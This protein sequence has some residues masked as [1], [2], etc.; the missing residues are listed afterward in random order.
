MMLLPQLIALQVGFS[1]KNIA[2]LCD[3]GGSTKESKV[4]FIGQKGIGFRSVFRVTNKPS[5]HS[6]GYHIAFDLSAP[7][8]KLNYILPTWV[9]PEYLA[10]TPVAQGS[11]EVA[12]ELRSGQWRTI[13][14]LPKKQSNNSE[15]GVR[16]GVDDDAVS[17]QFSE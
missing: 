15:G 12:E 17:F 13:I 16:G 4:G 11:S 2:A 8:G 5:V 10:A 6:S 7:E 14:H 1:R 3:M 9:G